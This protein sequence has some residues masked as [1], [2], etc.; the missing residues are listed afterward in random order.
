MYFLLRQSPSGNGV[1]EKYKKLK[2]LELRAWQGSCSSSSEPILHA[3]GAQMVE[4]G[5]NVLQNRNAS[6]PILVADDSEVVRRGIRLLLAAQTEIAIV[7]EAANFAQ[8]FQMA[9][10]LDPRVIVMDLHMPDERSIHPQEV[11]SR[12]NQGPEV[13]AISV[14]NDEDTKELAENLGAA[15][16]LDKM[17]LASTL[18]PTITRLGRERGAAA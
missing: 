14:W 18:I 1:D 8:L 13:L 17:D 6:I 9:G 16:L 11:K 7:G 15:A 4:R 12:L 10:D 2:D 3:G 5:S